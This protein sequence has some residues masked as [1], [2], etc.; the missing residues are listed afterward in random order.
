MRWTLKGAFDYITK[1]GGGGGGGSAQ[2]AVTSFS[3]NLL[4]S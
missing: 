1:K 3:Y 2:T 4:V